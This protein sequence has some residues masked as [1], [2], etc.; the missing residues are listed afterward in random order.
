MRYQ[1]AL[2]A[3]AASLSSASFAATPQ[4]YAALDRASAAACARAAGLGSA[5][6]GPP[7]R[8]SDRMGVD[9]RL[10]AGRWRQPHMNGAPAK[11]LCLYDRRTRRVEVQELADD[12]GGAPEPGTSLVQRDIVWRAV[13]I[14]GRP[15][16]GGRPVTVNFG[17][18]G[19]LTGVSGCNNY[20]A[21]YQ[22]DG[23]RLAVYPP[24][25][26]TR[27]ACGP[28]VDAQER[29]F[30]GILERARSISPGPRGAIV[31]TADNGDAVMLERQ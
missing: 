21:R 23:A 4:S 16:V 2:L 13:E 19:K 18:D 8:F 6:V 3:F 28:A 24:M 14:D 22:L 29:R 31:L 20:S 1:C 25:I 15:P 7:A 10:V 27:M 11:L 12:S 26:G 9:A 30:Q 17:S 5:K